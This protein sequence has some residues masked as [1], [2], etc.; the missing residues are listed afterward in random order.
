MVPSSPTS[1]GRDAE[2]LYE[3]HFE[4]LV[5]LACEHQLPAGRAEEIVHEAILASVRHLPSIGDIGAWLTAAVATAA[6][7]EKP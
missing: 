6:R 7:A 2:R 5:R 4:R 1:D 3:L